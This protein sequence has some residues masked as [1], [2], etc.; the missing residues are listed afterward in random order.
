MV[1]GILKEARNFDVKPYWEEKKV[2]RFAL[3]SK[4][5]R[6]ETQKKNDRFAE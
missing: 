6:R 5:P 1:N 2:V 4:P 3:G